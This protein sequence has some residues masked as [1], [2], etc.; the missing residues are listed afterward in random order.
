VEQAT[1]GAQVAALFMR[2]CRLGSG[3]EC[4]RKLQAELRSPGV[5]V[6][7]VAT[8]TVR[9]QMANRTSA[10]HQHRCRE[11]SQFISASISAF[12][13]LEN[14][15]ILRRAACT[16][17]VLD[18]TTVTLE[19]HSISRGTTLLDS[20]ECKVVAYVDHCI[21]RIT[22]EKMMWPTKAAV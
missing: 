15:S 19:G 8:L 2:R 20:R 7:R 22:P 10:A 13:R 1:G 14:F 18:V 9:V 6:Y 4:F 11:S 5:T 12:I 17:G 16:Q 21:P 3:D